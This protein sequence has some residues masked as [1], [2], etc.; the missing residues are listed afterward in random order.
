MTSC[1]IAA[2][3]REVS[4]HTVRAQNRTG[5]I[6]WERYGFFHL[7]LMRSIIWF[8]SDQSVFSSESWLP[9]EWENGENLA[10]LDL[11]D[12]VEL[13]T[14]EWQYIKIA[15]QSHTCNPKFPS[16]IS[17]QAQVMG[18]PVWIIW[19]ALS[20]KMFSNTACVSL[21]SR[22]ISW[23]GIRTFSTI[24][25]I[26]FRMKH[27][28][29][30]A[31]KWFLKFWLSWKQEQADRLLVAQGE[32]GLQKL[33]TKRYSKDFWHLRVWHRNA[34]LSWRAVKP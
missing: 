28:L 29:K 10:N 5:G 26:L 9:I 2:A 27:H 3:V 21:I 14:L 32:S 30:Q 18:I 15:M 23:V 4:H 7:R 11:V 34:F 8:T 24:V 20:R 17:F 6:L 16:R 25:S 12:P 33:H 31:L 22:H 1:D 13:S 19:K